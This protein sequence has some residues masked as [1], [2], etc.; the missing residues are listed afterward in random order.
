MLNIDL[1]SIREMVD[2]QTKGLLK[3]TTILE[4]YLKR[5]DHYNPTLNAIIEQAPL[6]QL[7]NSAESAD[8]DAIAGA[9]H[10]ALHGIPITVKDAMHAKGFHP[11]RGV[12]ELHGNKSTKDA[13]VLTRLKNEGAIP[14]GLTNVPEMCMSFDTHNALYGRTLNSYNVSYSCGGSSGGEAVAIASG[15]S[16]G[17]IASDACGSVRIPAHFNGVCG[18]K[19]TQGRVP[20]TGQFPKDRSG[21]FHLTSSFGVMGRFVDDVDVLAS[22]IHGGD[23]QDPDTIS[24]PYQD[25]RQCDI[26]GMKVGVWRGESTNVELTPDVER[27]LQMVEDLLARQVSLVQPLTPPLIREACD[28]IWKLFVLGGDGSRGWKNVYQ[29]MSKTEFTPEIEAI[30]RQ[31]ETLEMTPDE[32]KSA[33]ITR[34]TFRHQLN[35]MFNQVDVLISPVYPDVA[36]KNG[37]SMDNIDNYSFVFPFSLSGSPALVIPVT[38]CSQTGMP[39]GVQIVGKNWSE[40]QIL[41]IASALENDLRYPMFDNIPSN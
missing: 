17:G 12:K 33:M 37:T 36:F 30:L 38:H 20:L 40:H 3:S 23:G 11:S 24:V 8:G 25:Y 9:L 2:C 7:L 13:T 6:P 14:L 21:L 5:Y 19:L 41:A 31:S 16:P 39:I 26:Q 10:G 22:L 35:L 29:Q 27:A 32:V 18:F 4:H 34:D 28:V 1:L 15:M